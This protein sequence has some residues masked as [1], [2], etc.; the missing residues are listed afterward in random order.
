ML[1][2]D[3]FEAIFKTEGYKGRMESKMKKKKKKKTKKQ[4]QEALNQNKI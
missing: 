3:K 1:D 2:Q 4:S